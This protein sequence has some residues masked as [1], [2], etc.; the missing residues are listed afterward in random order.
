MNRKNEKMKNLK[1][2]YPENIITPDQRQAYR[3]NQRAIAAGTEPKIREYKYQ[4]PTEIDTPEK[5]QAYRRAQ[6][7]LLKSE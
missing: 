4:Y 7:K 1:Y 5:R 3:R 2:D 6:R